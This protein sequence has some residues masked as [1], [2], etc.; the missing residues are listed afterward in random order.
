MTSISLFG[1]RGGLGSDDRVGG[2]GGR[3]PCRTKKPAAMKMPQQPQ[4]E[5]AKTTSWSPSMEAAIDDA[6]GGSCRRRASQLIV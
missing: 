2:S 5:I 4:K 3:R 6:R 1:L